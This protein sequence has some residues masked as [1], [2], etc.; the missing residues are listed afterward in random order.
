M[1][2]L[3]ISA[4]FTAGLTSVMPAAVAQTA[5]PQTN[6]PQ[7]RHAEQDH[8]AKRPFRLPSERVEARLAYLQTALK[9]T[10]AQK[11][12]WENFASAMRRQARESDKRVQEGR[13]QMAEHS[14]RQRL[15]TIERLE[16]RQQMMAAGAQRLNELIVAGKPLYA[17]FT[18][19]QKQIAD[20]LLAPRHGRGG[21]NRH[22][23]MRGSA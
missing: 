21:H 20:G 3:L 4:F 17:A 6:A 1:N 23:G 13:A 16:R 9:I 11:P 22:R 19:E 14:D 10:D 7:A 15:S 8:H 12:Q 2:K 5:A 18:P